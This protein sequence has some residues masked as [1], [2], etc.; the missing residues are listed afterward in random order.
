[1]IRRQ[2]LLAGAVLVYSVC[3]YA[4]VTGRLTGSVVDSTGSSVPNAKVSLVLPAGQQ[5]VTTAETS[6]EGLFAFPSLQPVTYDLTIEAPGFLR[7][8]LRNVKVDSGKE[9]PLPPIRLELST[10]SE[11]V[12]VS[13]NSEVVQTTNAEVAS[14]VTTEQIRRLPLLN[15]SL[16]S[17]L[18]NAPGVQNSRGPT[19]INGMR[20]SY[21]N[22]TMDGINVQD[23]YIRQNTLTYQPN[24]LLIDQVAEFTVVTSNATAAAPGGS[25][26]IIFTTPSGNNQ[27]HGAGYWYNRNNK[28]AA[29]DWFDNFA[30]IPKAFLNQ[31]QIGGRLG[32]PIKKDR[33]FFYTNFE[34]IRLRQQTARNRTLLTES[35]RNGDFVYR[36]ATGAV[37][38]VNVLAL[39]GVS[40]DPVIADLI[41]KSP[42][43]SAANNFLRGDSQPGFIRN[44][45]GYSFQ[46]RDNRTR[47]NYLAK[48]DYILN[49][50]NAFAV[51]YAYNTDEDD[52][53]DAGADYSS[54]PA[55]TN[56]NHTHF[57][58]ASWRWNPKPEIVN[59]LRG[60]FNIA[61]GH[62]INSTTLP[63]YFVDGLIFQNPV[64]DF[65]NQ[66]RDTNTYNIS[67]IT[68]WFRG[69][70]NLQFGY[71]QQVVHTSPYENF[72][73]IPT[74]T[75]GMGTGQRAL[76]AA[77]FPGG[78]AANEL[79]TANNLLASLGG[80]VDSYTQNFNVTSRTSGFVPGA[81]NLRNYRI[82]NYAFF[83]QD[84]WKALRRLTINLG[85]RWEYQTPLRE[86]DSLLLVPELINGNYV[87]TLA[88]N[89]TVNFAGNTDTR[90]LY[91]RDFNNFGPNVSIAW[92]VFGNGKTAI[93]SG[94]SMFFVNDQVMT[95]VQ[96]SAVT[97]AGLT[98]TVSRTGL[99]GR[100]STGRPAITTP[101][102]EVPRTFE[103]NFA[104]APNSAAAALVD[105]K[106][107]T[108]Y[109]QQWNFGIQQDI[110]GN[111]IE[112]RYVGNKSTK[113][114]RAFDFNQINFRA[115]GFYEDFL[116]A[117][118]NGFLSRTAR[119]VFD[120]RYNSAIPGSQPTPVF[121]SIEL[122]GL[123]TNGTVQGL[124]ERGEVAQLAHTYVSS[125]FEIPFN[126][127]RNPLIYGGNVMTNY[128]NSSYNALQVEFRRRTRFGLT[129]YSNYTWSKV[130]SDALGD[131]QFLF[132]PFLDNNNPQI[133]R[134]RA[135]FDLTHNWKTSFVYDLPLGRGRRFASSGVAN[136]IAGGWSIS[137]LM[138]WQSGTPFSILSTR[139][140]I[141]RT[142][143]RSI[144]NTANS[145]LTKD[146]LDR[147]V[148]FFMTGN[149]PSFVDRSVV[150]PD[151]RAVGPD[152][153]P[154]AGQV[155]FN[156]EPGVPG[157]LQRRMFSGPSV[158]SFDAGIQKRFNITERHQLELRM[159]AVNILNHP[160]F[161]IGDESDQTNNQTVRFNVNQPTFGNIVES[162]TDRRVIQFG[163]YYRF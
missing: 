109:V 150:G 36:D 88:S 78:I 49:D 105:P 56:K 58:S 61:P 114:L 81:S 129:L 104:L 83:I 87:T 16:T 128:S 12:E 155:F 29:T 35:A 79:A 119:G 107:V 93:R 68:S 50:R 135:P 51:S 96:N 86:R 18:L 32:G 136:V 149:G 124:I 69:K 48:G 82:N 117:R 131:G 57:L 13:A 7:Y 76:T 1:M 146:E 92:D 140:T 122:G 67:N 11:T 9:T 23:N 121:N 144:S 70:H 162:F 74:Y 15:R 126:F 116:R 132:E 157:A 3:A 90:D 89:A 65:L 75:V 98:S 123:L 17:V 106:L 163:L 20:A 159:E 8:V 84:Q 39:G 55:I 21:A 52:R 103:E 110:K 19:V 72:D 2:S 44:T 133:E 101:E 127:Y 95:A 27:L 77:E 37:Q 154:F 99:S 112:I 158:F 59:E 141:N 130:L 62:F 142:G 118:S 47:N 161:Y 111:I 43:A 24:M 33:L 80:F 139:G 30:G 71:Q 115:G 22:V 6:A 31:N 54:I 152:G 53:S 100:L 25:S 38:R 28:F 147:V 91:K 153:R 151:G 113:Q 145:T 40:T 108:P 120:P 46:A 10:V 34:A 137:G 63:P 102:F 66:G 143:T 26:Q 148:G 73:V 94:Y 64:N 42:A 45:I 14:T 134:A 97:N 160:T 60:G 85:L 125:G 5:A 156:P 4:Q 41:A 138:G